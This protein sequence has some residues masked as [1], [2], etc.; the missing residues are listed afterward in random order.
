M[1]LCGI[2][3]RATSQQS[4]ILYNEFEKYTFEMTIK[5]SSAQLI[6]I[7]FNLQSMKIILWYYSGMH[8]GHLYAN[9]GPHDWQ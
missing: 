8:H 1:K 7:P 2:H 4:S 6:K 9:R 3:M 5:S